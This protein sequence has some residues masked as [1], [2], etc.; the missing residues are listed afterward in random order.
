MLSIGGG[1]NIDSAVGIPGCSSR[2][3][4]E[5]AIPQQELCLTPCATPWDSD[6]LKLLGTLLHPESQSK[7]TG[8]A[9]LSQEGNVE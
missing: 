5:S 4:W 2:R 8:T 9:S 1:P 7:S 6:T 3:A